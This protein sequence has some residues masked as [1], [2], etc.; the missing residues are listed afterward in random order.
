MAYTN[1]QFN[2]FAEDQIAG[3]PSAFPWAPAVGIGLPVAGFSAGFIRTKSGKRVWD[4]Y[5]KSMQH[6]EGTIPMGMFQTFHISETI[7]P[8]AAPQQIDLLASQHPDLFK[9]RGFRDYLSRTTGKGIGELDRLGAF[10]KGLFWKKT[11]SNLGQLRV[12][13]GPVIAENIAAVSTGARRTGFMV[14]WLGHVMGIKNPAFMKKLEETSGYIRPSWLFAGGGGDKGSKAKLLAR[15]AYAGVS[16]AVG[17]MNL[18]LQSPF[19]LEVVQDWTSKTPFLKSMNL[20]VK[21]GPAHKMLAR[22]ARK[23]AG[24]LL[25]YHALDYA[26]YFGRE[27]GQAATIPFGI[28]S[29]ATVGFAIG[30]R[31]GGSKKAAVIGAVVGGL[32]G[33]SGEGPLST[34]ASTYARLRVGQA[35]VSDTTGLGSGARRTEDFFP[36]LTKPTTLVA[37]AALGLLLGGVKD[38]GQKLSLLRA[39]GKKGKS[40]KGGGASARGIYELADEAINRRREKL[41]QHYQGRAAKQIGLGKLVSEF[42]A[43]YHGSIKGGKF[44]AAGA[45]RTAMVGVALYSALNIVGSAV[46]GDYTGAALGAAATGAAGYAYAKKGGAL[47]LGIMFAA[48]LLRE[49]TD[50]EKLKRIYRGEEKVAI[51]SGRWWEM[52]RTPYEG[53]RPYYRPHRVAMLRSGADKAALYGDESNYWS[54]DPFF[55]PLEFLRNPYAREELM[56]EQGYKFPVSKTP[57]EDAPILGPVLAATIG[58][59]LKPP[60]FMGEEEWRAE[61]FGAGPGGMSE[62]SRGEAIQKTGI[63]GTIGEQA[64]RMTELVGLPG[65]VMQSIKGT[66]TGH[67]TFFEEDQWATPSIVAGAEPGWWS[68]EMGGLGMMCIPGSSPVQ[69]MN[70]IISIQDVKPGDFVLSRD[71]QFHQVENISSRQTS[72]TI[73]VRTACFNPGLEATSNHIVPVLQGSNNQIFDKPL[74][75]V[76]PGDFLEVPLPVDLFG[77][78]EIDLTRVDDVTTKDYI[79][80]GST[81]Y[82]ASAYEIIERSHGDVTRRELR[83]IGIPD[84]YGKEAL[85]S[86]RKNKEPQRFPRKIL[87]DSDLAYLLGWYAAKGCS[88]GNGTKFTLHVKEESVAEEIGLLCR[89]KF[90]ATFSIYK[91][92]KQNTAV[93]QIQSLLFRRIVESLLGKGNQNK[94][95]SQYL[96]NSSKENRAEFLRAYIAG[97]GFVN[98]EKR[99]SGVTSTSRNLAIQAYLMSLSLGFRGHITLD[100]KVLNCQSRYKVCWTRWTTDELF[101]FFDQE[102]DVLFVEWRTNKAFVTKNKLY[103]RV[104]ETEYIHDVK[105]VYDLAINGLH[106]FTAEFIT[107][108]NSEGIRRYIPHRRN[109]IDYKNPL[110]SDLPSWLPGKDSQYFLDFSSA[111]IYSKIKEPWARLPGAGLAA[112]NPELKGVNPEYYSDFWKF[113]VLGDVAPWSKE[114]GTYDR[115][116]SEAQARHRLTAEQSLEVDTIRRQVRETKKAKHFQQYRYDNQTIEKRTVRVTEELEPG[117]YLTDTFGSAPIT[118]A[119]VNTSSGS[120]GNVARL[121]D[122]SLTAR[123]AMQ[124]GQ[125]KQAQISDFL[126]EYVYPGAEIDVFVHKDPSNLMSRGASGTPQ[127]QAVVSVGGVNLNRE[128]VERGLAESLA[129]GEALDPMMATGSI[130]RSFGGFWEGLAHGAETPLESLTPAAPVAKFV[131]QRTALEEYQRSEV[132]GKEIALWQKPLEHFIAPGLTT[133]AWWAGWRGLPRQVQERYM[134]EEYFDRLENEKWNRLGRQASA[135]EDGRLAAKYQ[136]AAGRTKTGVNVFSEHAV[137]RALSSKERAYFNEFVNSP[138]AAERRDISQIV[139]PQLNRI[140]QAQWARRAAEGAQMRQEAGIGIG[141]DL[142]AI[143]NYDAMRGS[144]EQPSQVSGGG[145]NPMPMPGPEWVGWDPNT[146]TEDFKVK[147]ILDKNMDAASYGV[148]RS[149]IRRIER[150]PWVSSISMEAPNRQVI[151]TGAIKR[152]FNGLRNQS[153][154]SLPYLQVTSGE[155]R[156]E[157]ASPGYDRVQRYLR[158]PSIMQF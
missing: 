85:D 25:T 103:I 17:R 20:G 113:K 150:R 13:G 102:I 64:Y 57:F 55:H 15:Y 152:R 31:R 33:L 7:S 119:G 41:Y 75:E 127:V 8:L 143:A 38:W 23:G 147:T 48:S 67:D 49:R 1:E 139:S 112:L 84:Q 126:R 18:L 155:R 91:Q 53:K 62:V 74:G 135:K 117:V 121:A 87:L 149:D 21:A 100:Y 158:D 6:V 95:V 11:G 4:V 107:V 123:Q 5:F 65:F 129:D 93:L 50:P 106:Y 140:L 42:R 105:E 157:V 109:E 115:V 73:S 52:G 59:V 30:A 128:L 111:N 43:R 138:T 71:S 47:G 146:E 60:K 40:S 124:S 89:Y 2:Q 108:H 45:G 110:P 66:L 154:S 80:Y 19:D 142:D 63:K 37:S 44:Q 78:S 70:G 27:Y 9:S 136:R 98:F 35:E 125:A 116:L 97:D 14:E 72:D 12:R 122:A 29:G 151:S 92:V 153:G 120:L 141:G 114:F 132:Y 36:G 28:A 104:E 10:N 131:H 61:S 86:Y 118:L 156:I 68:L 94:E 79:Y 3:P 133:T 46:A 56:W 81:Q 69:T 39:A 34:L 22:Y 145:E 88:S 101:K 16:S 24:V 96:Y 26:D 58:R 77:A 54:T 99:K 137:R 148:W 82:F 83:D 51:K 32:L 76:K 130:R 144:V 90:G 134:V